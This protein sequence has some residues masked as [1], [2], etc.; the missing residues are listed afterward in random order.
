MLHGTVILFTHLIPC[1]QNYVKGDENVIHFEEEM[2]KISKTFSVMKKTKLI[3]FLVCHPCNRINPDPEYHVAPQYGNLYT[4]QYLRDK[5]TLEQISWEKILSL[6]RNIFCHEYS[7]DWICL[8]ELSKNVL[9]YFESL[10]GFSDFISLYYN[11]V[12]QKSIYQQANMF[13][14]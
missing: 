4:P 11:L 7:P 2:D 1:C 14:F 10:K 6:I 3:D 5:Q 9:D 8:K 13:F 12:L